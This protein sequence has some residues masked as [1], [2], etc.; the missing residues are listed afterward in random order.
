MRITGLILTL[1]I[2]TSA[3]AQENSP[4]SRYGLGD[5]VPGQNIMARGMG[6]ISAGFSDN[7]VVNFINP[8][9][10]GNFNYYDSSIMKRIAMAPSRTIF[11]FGFEIDTRNLKQIDPA[12]K[13]SATNLIVSYV[14]LGLPIRL[15][16]ANKKGVFLGMNFGLRPVSR[17]NYKVL[18]T[19]RLQGVDSIGSL[20]EGSGGVNEAL[21][22]A[23]L[24]IK[25][26][27]IGFNTGYRFGNK[28]F[29][30]IRSILNDTVYHYQSNSETSSN[31][32][33]L[34][35][36][37]GTQYEFKF[38][39]NPAEP[40]RGAVLRLGAYASLKQTL[41][42]SQDVLRQT[43]KYD[44]ENGIYQVDSIFKS[45]SDG[46][47]QYP[48]TWG[49]GFTYRDSS[50][51]WTVGAD[52]ETTSWKDYRFFGE[53]DSV[54]NSWRIHAGFEYYPAERTTPIRKYFSFV[55]YRAGFYYGP[56]YVNIGNSM[57]EYAFTAG[58]G[59]PLKLRPSYGNDQ[60]SYL[61]TTFEFGSR[62]NKS[63]NLR[64][65]FF[66]ISFG[67]SL[68]DIWFNRSKYY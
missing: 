45:T 1:F 48:L 68:S 15:R 66:R 27:N 14:Q 16:K 13:F 12:A 3:T 8:A 4:Y 26:F 37:L 31:F 46:K 42:A 61:N 59:I 58:L 21:V 47:V 7:E 56:S 33:G 19:E 22:G 63:T 17:I 29:N 30:T 53:K 11:D 25:N 41:N 18:T 52:Y 39:R 51:H 6:G 34:F 32:G 67:L 55:K 43:V 54:Q 23:G 10:Y 50:G 38:K 60:Y 36:T 20:Y 64:E 44:V 2:Y 40:A 35:Y 5:I 57:P 28:K 24:R 62:G 9:S 49:A 65:S